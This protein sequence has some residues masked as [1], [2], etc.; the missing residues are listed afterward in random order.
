MKTI[1]TINPE[2]IRD[3]KNGRKFKPNSINLKLVNNDIN[4]PTNKG[5]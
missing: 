4:M 2:M 1:A 5:K 3:L